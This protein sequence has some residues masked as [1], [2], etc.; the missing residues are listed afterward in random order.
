MLS[1]G[2]NP[3]LLLLSLVGA[4]LLTYWAYRQTT[5]H[6]GSGRRAALMALRFAALSVVLFLLFEPVLRLLQRATHA[7]V[8]AVLVDTSQSLGLRNE[9]GGPAFDLAET[10]RQALHQI[11][12]GEVPGEVRLF[13]FDGETHL[14][15]GTEGWIDSLA[16][17]GARTNLAQALDYVRDAL[18]NDPLRGVLLVSDV[19]HNTGR[20]PIYTAERYPVPIHTVVVGDTTQRRDVQLR[21]VT[22]NELGYVGT[23]VPVQVGLRAEAYPNERVSV[24]LVQNGQVLSSQPVQLGST[25]EEV[26]VDLRFT[27]AQA[28]LQRLTVSVSRLP[29]EATWRNNAETIAIR[30]LENRRQVLLLAPAPTPDLAALRQLFEADPDLSITTLTQ[31]QQGQYYEGPPPTDLGRFD[32]I[33]LV[34]YPGTAADVALLDRVVQAAQNGTPLVFLLDRLTDQRLLAQRLGTVLPATPQV[35]RPGFVEATLVPSAQGTLHPVMG[36]QDGSD[37]GLWRQLPPLLTSESR[38]QVSPD[39]RVLGVTQVQGVPLNDPVLVVRERGR[40]RTAALLGSGTWRWKNLPADLEA[41]APLWPT[42]FENLNRW[43]TTPQ[44]NRPVR[45]QPIQDVFAGGEDVQFTGQ[46]YDES[47]QPVSTAEVDVTVTTPDARELPYR[48]QSVGNGRYLLNSGPLPEGTYRF[49]A[50]ARR[51]DT[52]LG[53]DAGTFAV[54]GVTLEYR[55]TRA[56]AALMRQIA[57]RSG[58]LFLSPGETAGIPA[59][60]AASD[61]FRPTVI[62][63]TQEVELW[64]RFGFLAAVLL[65]LTVEWFLRK[66]NGLA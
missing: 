8:L 7:P 1:F 33:V 61:T 52:N 49:T 46:V 39:A 44:D 56:N 62:E 57:Q 48:M 23:E 18:R 53:T 47:L 66:R 6:L 11:P 59:R 55:E 12:V 37:P 50:Q 20:N 25:P 63:E 14:H 4:A 36:T 28:G 2:L 21:R 30:I 64:H 32:L 15:P 22:T 29:G 35:I 26:P 65:L 41:A 16:F 9:E 38:W 45:V 10:V 40:L 42:L 5:P 13:T 34:G 17:D 19:N 43:V 51:V 31:K 54:G 58:G 60:L 27:P 3:W 24:S